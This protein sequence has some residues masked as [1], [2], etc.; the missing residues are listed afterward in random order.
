MN[1]DYLWNK[2]GPPDA[3]VAR[4]EQTLSAFRQTPGRPAWLKEFVAEQETPIIQRIAP[5][6]VRRRWW[7]QFL[8]T[9]QAAFAAVALCVLAGGLWFATRRN[10][11]SERANAIA[12]AL[13]PAPLVNAPAIQT[14]APTPISVVKST[15]AAAPPRFV[16]ARWTTP[17]RRVVKLPSEEAFAPAEA[18]VTPEEGRKAIADLGVAMR[19]LNEKLNLAGKNAET[20]AIV[21]PVTLSLARK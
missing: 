1:E 2:E 16:N 21:L 20:P 9:P 17:P 10:A 15:V 5:I 7:E 3:E 12:N 4:L 8:L 13:N 6:I 19:L 14:P 11:P 18:E